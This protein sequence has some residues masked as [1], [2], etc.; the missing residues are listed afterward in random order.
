MIYCSTRSKFT[1]KRTGK[2][3]FSLITPDEF[4]RAFC[5]VVAVVLYISTGFLVCS[6]DHRQASIF[7]VSQIQI[8]DGRS[9]SIHPGSGIQMDKD[10]LPLLEDQNPVRR[11]EIL[12]GTGRVKIS[13]TNA[14]K[15]LSNVS[16]READVTNIYMHQSVGS[17]SRRLHQCSEGSHLIRVLVYLSERERSA[18]RACMSCAGTFTTIHLFTW[19]IRPH[20][21]LKCV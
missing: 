14:V 17:R 16:G 21:G 8:L 9:E 15:S 7:E 13:L 19:L 20:I 6:R 18:G 11:S 12:S 5:I 4:H 3:F 10:H 1:N 2:N